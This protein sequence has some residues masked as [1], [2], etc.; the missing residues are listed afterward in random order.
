[1]VKIRRYLADEYPI[2]VGISSSLFIVNGI[3]NYKLTKRVI[4]SKD[5]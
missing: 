3:Y 1:M 5:V 2:R 4:I